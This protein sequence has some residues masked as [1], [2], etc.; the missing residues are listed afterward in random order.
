M[1]TDQG[2]FATKNFNAVVQNL[3]KQDAEELLRLLAVR[4]AMF[5]SL[6]AQEGAKDFV[7]GFY[8]LIDEVLAEIKKKDTRFSCK[9]GCHA[10]CRINVDISEAEA[11]VIADYCQEHDIQIP[12]GYLQ[13]QLEYDEMAVSRSS[14]AS[15]IFLKEGEC[16]IYAVRPAA[17]RIYHVA[18]PPE[19]C[20]VVKFPPSKFKV[21]VIVWHLPELEISAFYATVDEKDKFGRMPQMLLP[22][23][24]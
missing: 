11:I 10:C 6:C 1:T 12:K 16:S 13:K 23:S 24:K 19:M 8:E 21:R 20:D 14:V 9:R 5:K 3:S 18:S 7:L 2:I 4:T 17:C 22:Y 15:C